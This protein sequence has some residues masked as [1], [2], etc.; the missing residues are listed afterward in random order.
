MDL[1]TNVVVWT[2][3]DSTNAIDDSWFYGK[4]GK[5][6]VTK[7]SCLSSLQVTIQATLPLQISYFPRIYKCIGGSKL[8]INLPAVRVQMQ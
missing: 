8:F 7:N 6:Y 5:I 2:S 4:M 3:F 1:T